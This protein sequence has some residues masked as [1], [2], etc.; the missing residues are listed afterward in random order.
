MAGD[1]P[2]RGGMSRPGR[3]LD[4]QG[5]KGG[6]GADRKRRCQA[7][8]QSHGAAC[9]RGGVQRIVRTAK[10][11]SERHACSLE[12]GY[13]VSK[14]GNKDMRKRILSA[15]MA[16]CLMLTMLPVN[17]LAADPTT[18]GDI[19]KNQATYSVGGLNITKTLTKEDGNLSLQLEA[20]VT[21]TVTP[22]ETKPLDIVLVLDVSGSMDNTFTSETRYTYDL[23]TGQSNRYIW[24]DSDNLYTLLE[25]GETYVPVEMSREPEYMDSYEEAVDWRDR[26]WTNETCYNYSDRYALYY[27]DSESG[28]YQ[29]VTVER[30]HQ[31]PELP[32]YLLCGRG[33]YLHFW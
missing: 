29:T 5:E 33:C 20:Y 1:R 14:G 13:F 28:E 23:I 26:N 16:L 15:C 32:I 27:Y 7:R 22:I 12:E 30:T 9:G 10:R 11:S 18:T 19:G 4:K 17:A 6:S 31:P 8:A 24:W 21:G 2:D 25:D 3:I